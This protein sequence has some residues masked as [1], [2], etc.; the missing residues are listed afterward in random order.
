MCCSGGPRHTFDKA[1]SLVV[2][3]ADG[4]PDLEI[5]LPCPDLPEVVLR[6]IAGI[7]VSMNAGYVHSMRASP[8]AG[9]TPFCPFMMGPWL[10]TPACSLF[11]VIALH[12]STS[13]LQAHESVSK[14]EA[15]AVWEEERRV[16]K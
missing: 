2:L 8:M 15:T 3:G 7:N 1:Q 12:Q 14:Q 6:S 9:H 11:M 16:S 4:K 5:P 10:M 13:P